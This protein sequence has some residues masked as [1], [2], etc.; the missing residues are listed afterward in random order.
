MVRADP[1]FGIQ[2]GVISTNDPVLR[3]LYERVEKSLDAA[4]TSVRATI[5][6]ERNP[7]FMVNVSD[8]GMPLCPT[9][10]GLP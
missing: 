3:R 7:Q 2:T 5:A 1:T 6:L 9:S 10:A 4:D 8:I